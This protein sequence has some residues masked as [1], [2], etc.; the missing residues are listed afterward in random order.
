MSSESPSCAFSVLCIDRWFVFMLELPSFT[1]NMDIYIFETQFHW[2][3]LIAASQ[4]QSTSVRRESGSTQ[5]E[6]LIQ[7]MLLVWSGR[8]IKQEDFCPLPVKE[9]R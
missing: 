5:D 8:N 2:N 7:L 4:S 3:Q 6:K 1:K 9:Q